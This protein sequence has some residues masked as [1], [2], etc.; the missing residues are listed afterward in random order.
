MELSLKFQVCLVLEGHTSLGPEEKEV[1]VGKHPRATAI[2]ITVPS[3]QPGSK[4]SPSFRSPIS[5]AIPAASS[6]ASNMR[7]STDNAEGNSP[8]PNA[9]CPAPVN[10][11]IL[12][13]R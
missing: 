6:I 13:L 1:Q 12:R 9:L 11:R 8:N 7:H 3:S 2:R 10:R 4:T 5:L